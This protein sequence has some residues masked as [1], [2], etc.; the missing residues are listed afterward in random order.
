MPT[1]SRIVLLKLQPSPRLRV[2][3]VLMTRTTLLLCGAPVLLLLTLLCARDLGAQNGRVADPAPPRVLKLPETPP[4]SARKQPELT[5]HAAPKPL[6][7]GAVT[8]DWRNFLGPTFNGVST[9][10][11]LAARFGPNGPRR[12][13]EVSKGDG[14]ASPAVV[15]ER[16]ILFHRVGAN[17]VVECLQA[18][19]GRRFWRV[20][21]PTGYQDRYGFSGGPRCQPVSDGTFVYTLGAEGTLHCLKLTTGQVLWKRELLREFRVRQNFFGVGAT[22]LLDGERLIVNVGAPAG[23]CLAAFHKETGRLLWGAGKE[24]SPGY[25]APVP[26]TLAGKRRILVFTGGESRPTDGGLLCVDPADGRVVFQFPWRSRTYES[27][28]ASCPVAVGNRVFVSECYGRGGVLLEANAAGPFRTVWTSRSLGTHFMTAIHH[29]GHLYGIDGHGPTNAP[30]VCISLQTGKELWRHEPQW[31]D[32][33][34]TPGGV[35]KLASAPALASLIKV[36]GRGL[37]LGQYGNLAWLDLN[38]NGYKEL[39]RVRLFA[40]QETWSM[41]ALSRGL[42]YVCQ[43]DAGLDGTRPRLLCLDLRGTKP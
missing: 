21:Y 23:P 9:E 6:A 42:L 3:S 26:A 38:P 32:Q 1:L 29:N 16:V 34:R 17:E 25:G 28:N 27:V 24:W 18:E 7:P 33:V 40:A 39:D 31:E 5:F 13:W 4:E 41:P 2:S 22:P 12:V 36:D 10:R 11:P 37:L 35:R 30:L 20:A 8:H 19:S 43:N 15:G 14:Y